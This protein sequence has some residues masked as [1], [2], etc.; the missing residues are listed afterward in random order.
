MPTEMTG[1]LA[2]ASSA[3]DDAEL[4]MASLTDSERFAA[5]FDRH[6]EPIHHYVARRVGTDAADDIVAETFLTAFRRRS[7]YD[8]ARPDARPWLYGIATTLVAR[9]RRS[10][11]RYL[12]AL[13]R[14]GVDPLP[15]SPADGVVERITA[16]DHMRRLAGAL[17]TLGRGDRDTLLLVVWGEL[18]YEEAARALGIPVGTVRSRLNRARRKLRERL[19]GVDPMKEAH[20]G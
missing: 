9:H 15:E 10:E 16:Q 20:D 8:P 11:V 5:I 19:G 13:S 7:S 6:A 17:A 14:T 18:T 1:A 3:A 4:I 12:R 2:A